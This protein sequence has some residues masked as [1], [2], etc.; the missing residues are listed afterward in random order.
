MSYSEII[1]RISQCITLFGFEYNGIEGNIDPCYNSKRKCNEFLLY[2]N[3][4]EQTVYS[5]E[6]VEK[7]S[8][9][10]GKKLE[11]V[12]DDLVITEY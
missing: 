10:D 4:Q 6:D 12:F 5:I 1:D 8:F 3:G 2:F 11:D 7:A 9:I